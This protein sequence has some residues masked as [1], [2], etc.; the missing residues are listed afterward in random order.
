MIALGTTLPK[1]LRLAAEIV[2]LAA[3]YWHALQ[4]GSPHVLDGRELDAVRE[5]FA[6][7]GQQKPRTR[8]SW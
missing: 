8:R 7:Y 4:I 3:Q 6:E 2:T 1:A 5:R